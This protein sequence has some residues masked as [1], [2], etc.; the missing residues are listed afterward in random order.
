M[1]RVFIALAF[2][3]VPSAAKA[4]SC[5]IPYVFT[6]GTPAIAANVKAILLPHMFGTP[7]RDAGRICSMGLPVIE[8]ITLSAGVGIPPAGSSGCLTICSFHSSKLFQCGDGGMLVARTE[9]LLEKARWWNGWTR[10]PYAVQLERPHV[11]RFNFRMTSIA[12]MV[13]LNGL[14]GLGKKIYRRQQLADE[15]SRRLSG[16]RVP[17]GALSGYHRYLVAV[18]RGTVETKQNRFRQ[19]GLAVGR[20]VWPAIHQWLHVP[21]W[22]FPAAARCTETLLSLPLYPSL[23]KDQGN[24][25]IDRCLEILP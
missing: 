7:V 12:A 17:D 18:D 16:L 3:L 9:E 19:A 21:D 5:S 2:L 8:D 11:P 22:Q 14:A 25:L 23:T 13:G 1:K 6:A 15:Y 20:G 10:E 4:T 24:Y